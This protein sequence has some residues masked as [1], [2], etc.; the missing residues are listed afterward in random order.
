MIPFPG[1][2]FFSR[3]RDKAAALPKRRW[4]QW[5]GLG[6]SVAA[7]CVYIFLCVTHKACMCVAPYTSVFKEWTGTSM[8]VFYSV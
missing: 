5:P 2:N 6:L 8:A 7:V 3:E 1:P 4:K